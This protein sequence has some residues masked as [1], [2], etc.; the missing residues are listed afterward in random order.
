MYL[1]QM[2]DSFESNSL[3]HFV[4]T[5]LSTKSHSPKFRSHFNSLICFYSFYRRGLPS[6]KT[7]HSHRDPSR[8]QRCVE[9]QQ[10]TNAARCLNRRIV[11]DAQ[12]SLTCSVRRRRQLSVNGA[13]VCTVSSTLDR[14]LT[15]SSGRPTP[16]APTWPPLSRPP[17]TGPLSGYATGASSSG[18]LH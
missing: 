3:R 17:P 4:L 5:T 9:L 6:P 16:Q 10:L 1:L 14:R 18:R 8:S 15:P 7:S 2:N 12:T 13:S 11:C